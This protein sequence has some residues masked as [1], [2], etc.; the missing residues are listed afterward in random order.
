MRLSEHFDLSEFAC[1][2]CGATLINDD[3]WRLAHM[4]QELRYRC[5]SPIIITSGYRC[6]VHDYN[7]GTSKVPGSGPHTLSKALDCYARAIDNDMFYNYACEVFP[8]VIKYDKDQFC[9]V[10]F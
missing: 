3:F 9:H 5:N 1:K 10:G 8:I 4:I 7:V 6:S 2:H